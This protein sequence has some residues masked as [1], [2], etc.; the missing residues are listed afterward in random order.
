MELKYLMLKCEEAL[1]KDNELSGYK[2]IK[3]KTRAK[4]LYYMHELICQCNDEELY[5]W[6]IEI[7]PDEPSTEDIISIAYDDDLFMECFGTFINII[8]DEDYL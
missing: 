2:K 5:Q 3:I 7:F 4:Q 8:Q 6:W 1:K